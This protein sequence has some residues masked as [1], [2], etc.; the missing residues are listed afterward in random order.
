MNCPICN[1]HLITSDRQ[2]VEIDYCPGCRGIW[3]DRGE[4]DKIIQR[5]AAART[6]WYKYLYDADD[7][8]ATRAS[9]KH[10]KR[11][12]S[13]FIQY[14]VIKAKALRIIA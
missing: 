6:K 5:S 7:A 3:L 2:G 14:W 1:L 13:R 11:L 4:L 9:G 10:I 12:T 8:S